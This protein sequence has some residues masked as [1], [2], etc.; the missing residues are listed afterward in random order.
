MA[1]GVSLLVFVT[2]ALAGVFPAF[3]F[4]LHKRQ[5]QPLTSTRSLLNIFLLLHT[6]YYLYQV[7]VLPPVNIYTRL[8]VPVNTTA[9]SIRALL[10]QQS[11]TGDLPKPLETL[12][13]HL[14]SYDVKTYYIR[15]GHAVVSGCDYCQT[16]DEFGMFAF[17][18]ALI[19]YLCTAAVIGLVTILGSGREN[20]RTLAVAAVACAFVAETYYIL[21]V[22]IEIHPDGRSVIMWH[23]NL[24]TARRLFFLVLPLFVHMLPASASAAATNPTLA[25]VRVTEQALARVQ[26]LHMLRGA[27]MRVPLLRERAAAWWS[28][29]A[30]EGAWV[31]EDAGVQELARKLNLGFDDNGDDPAASQLRTQARNHVGV[32]KGSFAPSE[33]WRVAPT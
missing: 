28:A 8:K 26:L 27:T 10:I 14:G 18:A 17:P 23:D 7:I 24:Y 3:Y 32:L 19:S 31:R 16:F 29:E 12:L 13:R 9:D 30:Q 20:Y 22:P 15:F 4:G 2:T 6:L 11:D 1:A 5:Q 25:T 33:Y 21:T